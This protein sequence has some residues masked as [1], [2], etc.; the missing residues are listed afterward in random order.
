MAKTTTY[1]ELMKEIPA[2]LANRYGIEVPENRRLMIYKPHYLS[3]KLDGKIE[4]DINAFT[5]EI[6]TNSFTL[7]LWKDK[8]ITNLITWK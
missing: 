6:S 5:I 3:L 7:T 1:K 2:D 8:D 4:V